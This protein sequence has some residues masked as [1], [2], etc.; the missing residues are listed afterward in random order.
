M[1]ETLEMSDQTADQLNLFEEEVMRAPLCHLKCV[2]VPYTSS[3]THSLRWL[4]NI[5]RSIL[6]NAIH[7]AFK[8]CPE[9]NS[10]VATTCLGD[11]SAQQY[12]R[13]VIMQLGT[14]LNPE[15]VYGT[16]PFDHFAL[17]S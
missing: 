13:T 7:N 14:E 6:Y 8:T 4:P 1:L 5:C 11:S 12:Y 3:K 10:S 17:V 16:L 2:A 9:S 15:A